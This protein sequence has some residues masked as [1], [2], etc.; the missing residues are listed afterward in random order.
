MALDSR[1][2]IDMAA[3]AAIR[4]VVSLFCERCAMACDA[5]VAEEWHR[6]DE[7]FHLQHVAW[8]NLVA[9]V[10]KYEREELARERSGEIQEWLSPC[11]GAFARL[12]VEVEDKLTRLELEGCQ[13]GKLRRHLSAFRAGIPGSVNFLKGA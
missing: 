7:Y 6:F 8:L 2:S 5:L 13:T 9:L 11:Q 10:A 3:A 12:V 1:N 4:R